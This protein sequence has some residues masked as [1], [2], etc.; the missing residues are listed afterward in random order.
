[1]LICAWIKKKK[2]SVSDETWLLNL[3][4]YADFDGNIHLFCF[5]LEMHFLGKFGPKSYIFL[6]P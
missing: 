2:L 6:L 3:S 5:E 1:M 4:K